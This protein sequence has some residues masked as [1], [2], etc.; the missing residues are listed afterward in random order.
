MAIKDIKVTNNRLFEEWK[1]EIEFMSA[2]SCPYI[3]EVAGFSA[4]SNVLTIVMEY[5]EKGT[6]FNLLHKSGVRVPLF[7]RVRMA[8]HVA[9]AVAFLHANHVLHR[10]I[11]SLNVLITQD[12]I[13]KLSGVLY[14]GAV[15]LLI[16]HGADFGTAKVVHSDTIEAYQTQAAGTRARSSTVF[17]MHSVQ[18]SILDG[19]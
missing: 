19:A 7:N 4:T 13:A 15:R 3:I 18:I 6:L 11:K 10:D 17:H 1:K 9:I 5:A 2:H 12:D 8:R 16:S 14:F